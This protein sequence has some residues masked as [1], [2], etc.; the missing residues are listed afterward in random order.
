MR[1][2]RDRDFVQ[3]PEGFYFCV[4]GS[5]HPPERVISYIKY[6]PSD[7]G[8]WGDKEHKFKRIL[9]K[10]TI[11]D[12]LKTFQFIEENYPHYLFHSMEN[13]ITITAVPQKCIRTHFMPEKKLEKLRQTKQLDS[14][15]E[16]LLRFTDFLAQISGVSLDSFG[17]TG[18]LLL[19]IHQPSFS[20]IDL[21]V[22]GV[23]DSWALRNALTEH[24]GSETGMTYLQGEALQDWAIKKTQQYPLSAQDALK[25][26]ERKWNLGFFEN[27]YVS[28]HPVKLE[29]E[30]TENYG[31]NTYTPMGQVIIQ[32]V[33]LDNVDS[34][35]LPATYKI[36]DVKFLSGPEI[37]DITEVVTY[38][39]LYDS[40]AKNGETIQIKGKLE[41][42]TEKT[43]NQQHYR[44]VVGSAEGKGTEYIKIV[45]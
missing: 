35:F 1:G 40:L 18:S 17:V 6:V 16:K 42:V 39:G 36:K 3:T 13:N 38:E 20:D 7:S 32:A 11:P 4:I 27:K 31:D 22:Y 44:V 23:D 19:D 37:S 12:L 43:K 8:V 24:R 29:N 14:L 10:Y 5:V 21:I 26:Y 28:I 34:L 30:V 15:Q 25:M 2:F 9:Q 41:K 33:V 45:E